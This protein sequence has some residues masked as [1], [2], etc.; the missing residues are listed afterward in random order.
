M[1]INFRYQM[2]VSRLNMGETYQVYMSLYCTWCTYYIMTIHHRPNICS[3]YFAKKKK[4]HPPLL[5]S[6]TSTLLCV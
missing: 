4:K 3:N 1:N 2:S 5:S 6:T